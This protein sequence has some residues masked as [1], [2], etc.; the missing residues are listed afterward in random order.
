[1]NDLF[2]PDYFLFKHAD[3]TGVTNKAKAEAEKQQQQAAAPQKE[4]PPAVVQPPTPSAAAELSR[5]P[6]SETLSTPISGSTKAIIDQM[7][8]GVV[9]VSEQ[10]LQYAF[11]YVYERCKLVV[12]IHAATAVAA[13]LFGTKHLQDYDE[14]GI[15]LSGGNVDL[16][17]VPR[18]ASAR[19]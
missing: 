12:D 17:D 15:L 7:V 11:R 8:H 5:T 2:N 1:M 19:L 16:S 13:L 4:Q 9:K 6:V 3:P 10:Q 18:L 14:V